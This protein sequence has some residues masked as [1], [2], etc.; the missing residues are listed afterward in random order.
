MKGV[1]IM[2]VSGM[3]LLNR[4]SLWYRNVISRIWRI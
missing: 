4:N 3:V 2:K 1:L